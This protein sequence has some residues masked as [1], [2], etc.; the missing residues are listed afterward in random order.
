MI[1]PHNLI[2]LNLSSL[3]ST[4]HYH[5]QTYTGPTARFTA[6]MGQ[7]YTKMFTFYPFTDYYETS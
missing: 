3:S 1:T 7:L 2:N 6:S 5:C 4:F